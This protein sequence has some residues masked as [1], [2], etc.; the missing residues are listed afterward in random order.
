MPLRKPLIHRRRHQKAG[1]S[2][3]L[4]KIAHRRTQI[5]N[6]N[7]SRDA[8]QYHRTALLS[9]TGCYQAD[10][11]LLNFR[12][13]FG[14]ERRDVLMLWRNRLEVI[15]AKH[16]GREPAGVERVGTGLYCQHYG[17]SLSVEHWEETCEYYYTCDTLRSIPT[18]KNGAIA[19][20]KQSTPLTSCGPCTSGVT[21]S[22]RMRSRR[23]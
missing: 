11:E 9:P 7:R 18:E 23:D 8:T 10:C 22:S 5:S 20:V 2:V 16:H 15:F 6:Q 14:P 1:L 3:N 21:R 17:K 12:R 19:K 4:A 13:F